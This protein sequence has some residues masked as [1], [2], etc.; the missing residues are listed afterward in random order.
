MNINR[1]TLIKQGVSLTAIPGLLTAIENAQAQ[2]SSKTT[3]VVIYLYDGMTALDAVGPYES[4]RFLP[5]A[6]LIFAAKQKGLVKTDSRVLRLEATASIDEVNTAD[7][8]LIPGGGT[9]YAQMQDKTVVDWVRKLHANTRWTTSVCTGTGLLVAAGLLKGLKATTH[10]ASMLELRGL[11]VNAVSERIVREGKI[12]TAAG[13]SAGIDMALSLV[14]LEAGE[15][16]ARAI[17]LAIEYDPRPPFDSGSV[18]KASEQ[19]RKLARQL[20]A[21]NWKRAGS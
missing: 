14:A 11:G 16:L 21:D 19:T 13:V 1:R 20:L 8:L 3:T 4:L 6:N 15:E 17:Q 12:I 10:W 9:T 7:I 18:S 2:T 5:N